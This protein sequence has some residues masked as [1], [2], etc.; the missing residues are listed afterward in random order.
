MKENGNQGTPAGTS[1][2]PRKVFVTNGI[3]GR[4]RAEDGYRTYNKYKFPL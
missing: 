4:G 1:V 2:S 3:P